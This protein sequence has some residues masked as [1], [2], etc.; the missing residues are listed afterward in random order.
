M[1]HRVSLSRRGDWPQRAYPQSR[2]GSAAGFVIKTVINGLTFDGATIDPMRKPPRDALIAFMAA[3]A[4]AQA[5]GHEGGPEDR[6][7]AR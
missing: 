5:G 4:E 3:S 6:H 7:S 2:A 1:A